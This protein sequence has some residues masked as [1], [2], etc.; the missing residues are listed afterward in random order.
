MQC[1]LLWLPESGLFTGYFTPKSNHRSNRDADSAANVL[2]G[3]VAPVANPK[4]GVGGGG[5]N[6][7]GGF[8]NRPIDDRGG[9]AA[10]ERH[11]AYLRSL[12]G[13][14]SR[15]NLRGMEGAHRKGRGV[16]SVAARGAH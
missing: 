12:V 13:R 11:A 1:R 10:H 8:E 4:G 6:L 16:S 9:A 14:L 7:R 2:F 3:A 15:P 5:R